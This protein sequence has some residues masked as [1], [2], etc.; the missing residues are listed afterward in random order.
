[1]MQ[2]LDLKR[3]SSCSCNGADLRTESAGSSAGANNKTRWTESTQWK[4]LCFYQGNTDLLN[5]VSHTHWYLY[6]HVTMYVFSG[7][8]G[9][10]CLKKWASCLVWMVMYALR[11]L[12]EKW[13]FIFIPVWHVLYVPFPVLSIP[14]RRSVFH[15]LSLPFRFKSCSERLLGGSSEREPCLVFFCLPSWRIFPLGLEF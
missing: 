3:R 10:V 8:N 5:C 13:S 12:R 1:M 9:I 15:L 7:V 14:F 11:K 4:V 6:T 2:N